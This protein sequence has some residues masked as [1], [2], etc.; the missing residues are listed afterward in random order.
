MKNQGKLL[1]PKNPSNL[2]ETNPK[3]MKICDGLNKEFKIAVLR[4]LNGLQEN[5]ERQFNEIRKII[6]RKIRGL[7][8]DKGKGE[9]KR[10]RE[11]NQTEIMKL[12][13]T[14]SEMKKCNREK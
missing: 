2:P 1:T 10:E 12:K 13:Y 14:E 5:T 8:K 7:T 3:D 4:K 9:K 6:Q 11:R